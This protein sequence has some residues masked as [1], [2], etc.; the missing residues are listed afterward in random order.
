MN[1]HMIETHTILIINLNKKLKKNEFFY[2]NSYILIENRES[3]K[4]S[5]R[6]FCIRT[7]Y[8]YTLKRVEVNVSG[9]TLA[10]S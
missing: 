7:K 9:I 4:Q 8:V 2:F 10:E 1:I 6:V 3:S 5:R